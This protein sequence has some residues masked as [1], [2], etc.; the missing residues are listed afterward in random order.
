MFNLFCSIDY[1][2][3]IFNT[4]VKTVEYDQLLVSSKEELANLTPPPLSDEH[5]KEDKEA[6]IAKWKA[7]QEKVTENVPPTT[8]P[9]TVYTVLL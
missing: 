4:I 6:A 5:G 9:G 1:V 2:D 7:R 3:E 8:P